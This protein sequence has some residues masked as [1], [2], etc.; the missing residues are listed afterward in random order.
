MEDH[1]KRKHALLSAS[2]S[3]RWFNCT[4]SAR[5]EDE[6][7]VRVESDFAKEGTT[8]HMLGELYL[9]NDVL[10]SLSDDEFTDKLNEIMQLP[11][12]N[13]EMLIEVPKY[14]DYCIEIFEEA[15]QH[16][17]DALASIEGKFDLGTYIKEGFGSNDFAVLADGVLEVVDLK[18]G[19]GIAVKAEKNKQLMIYG[20]GALLKYAFMYDVKTVRL[21]IVQPRLDNISSWDI[22]YDD[23]IDWAET[24]LTTQA[25][26]AF[27][28]EGELNP[29]PWCKF[30]S[31]KA[32]CPKLADEN[33]E[34]AKMDF[35]DPKVKFLSDNDIAKILLQLPK[36]IDWAN[37]IAEYAASEAINNKKVWPGLKLV[38]GQARRKWLDEAVVVRK[39]RSEFPSA[40]DEDIFNTKLKTITEL[41]KLFTKKVFA[42]KL[43]DVVVKPQGKLSLVPESDSRPA[44]GLGQAKSDFAD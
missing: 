37:G 43:S 25:N 13:E 12:F 34:L 26:K 28:G 8:A 2:G 16:T 9:I 36:L 40:E 35:A 30:C 42:E 15:K 6:H 27:A 7:G 41:E 4:P 5:L 24:E 1:S 39:I 20:L 32:R 21:T 19:K 3:E 17:P 33:M 23:L 10:G 29:G 11:H 22:S 38:E 31:I 18:Y 44:A 14:V